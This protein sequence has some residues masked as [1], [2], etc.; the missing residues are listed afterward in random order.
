MNDALAFAGAIAAGLS[1][2]FYLAIT[3]V[4]GIPL[5]FVVLDLIA[6]GSRSLKRDI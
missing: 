4:T 6:F 3:L 1:Q 5:I 2:V